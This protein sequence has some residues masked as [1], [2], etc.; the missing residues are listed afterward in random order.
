MNH[1]LL[2]F[3]STKVYSKRPVILRD[4]MYYGFGVVQ[5]QIVYFDFKVVQDVVMYLKKLVSRMQLMNYTIREFQV[6]KVY[7]I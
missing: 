1:G 7:Q 2:V 4:A 6:T 5:S 3:Q